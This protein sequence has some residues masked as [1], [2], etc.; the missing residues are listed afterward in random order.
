MTLDHSSLNLIKTVGYKNIFN[1]LYSTIYKDSL[2][3]KE[4]EAKDGEYRRFF[5]NLIIECPEESLKL[6]TIDLSQD[7]TAVA[8]SLF[9]ELYSNHSKQND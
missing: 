9:L 3:F 2:P 4:I 8:S 7:P 5:E 6:V 1:Y